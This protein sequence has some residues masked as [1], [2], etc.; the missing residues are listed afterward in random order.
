MKQTRKI[1]CFYINQCCG[2]QL[3][4]RTK[5]NCAQ[6]ARTGGE[7][8][9]IAA[10]FVHDLELLLVGPA[11]VKDLATVGSN[12]VRQMPLL[13]QRNA[14]KHSLRFEAKFVC[15]LCISLIEDESQ[16]FL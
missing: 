3:V 12:I 1:P 16:P 7:P 10:R 13:L 14:R 6:C 8:S 4:P 9:V 15:E 2:Q 11:P 5:A